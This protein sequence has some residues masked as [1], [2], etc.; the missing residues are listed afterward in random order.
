MCNSISELFR[1]KNTWNKMS[2]EIKNERLSPK[3]ENKSL[4]E[5]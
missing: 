2:T 1:S 3:K 4:I 5:K